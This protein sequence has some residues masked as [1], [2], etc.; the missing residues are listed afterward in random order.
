MVGETG[1]GERLKPPFVDVVLHVHPHCGDDVNRRLGGN[2]ELDVCG[3]C[4]C[5]EFAR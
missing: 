2:A 5:K 1:F 3:V 4:Y